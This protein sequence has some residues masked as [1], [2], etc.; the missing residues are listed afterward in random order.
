MKGK[1]V[2]SVVVE[3]EVEVPDELIALTE[4]DWDDLTDKEYKR[5]DELSDSVWGEI[6]QSDRYGMYCGDLVVEEY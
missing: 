1:I 6:P 4:K 5:I 3:K 2:Y